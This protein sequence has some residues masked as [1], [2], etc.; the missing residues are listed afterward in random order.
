[1]REFQAQ[2]FLPFEPFNTAALLYII[3]TLLAAS[4]IKSL[5]KTI[6]RNRDSR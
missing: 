3:L 5:E 4:S 1:M 2:S 6:N